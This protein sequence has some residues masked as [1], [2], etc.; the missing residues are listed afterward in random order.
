MRPLLAL[1]LLLWAAP[2]LAQAPPLR[3][4]PGLTPGAVDDSMSPAQICRTQWGKDAR[5]VTAAMKR[6]VMA[7]YKMTPRRCPSGKIEIDHACS[8]EL[9]CRD[10]VRNLWPQCYEKPV[11]GKTPS[12]V[13]EWGAHKKDRLEN[14]MHKEVCTA[15]ASQQASVLARNR[16]DILEDWI[17]AYIHR[18]GYPR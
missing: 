12:E 5:H 6:Q 8:R 10:D 16:K 14:E 7:A 2:A 13:P 17:G 3:P 15:P 1:V 4:D 18:W 9:G 11:K